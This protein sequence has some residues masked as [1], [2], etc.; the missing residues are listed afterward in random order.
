MQD[1]PFVHGYRVQLETARV[2]GG[3]FFLSV[4][5]RVLRPRFVQSACT[6]QRFDSVFHV[7]SLYLLPVLERYLC[8]EVQRWYQSVSQY[9]DV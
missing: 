6:Q 1:A 5:D 4:V 3:F 7:P 8:Y 9:H 2:H